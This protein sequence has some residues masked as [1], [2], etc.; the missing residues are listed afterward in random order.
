MATPSSPTRVTEIFTFVTEGGVAIEDEFIP[1]DTDDENVDWAEYWDG[2]NDSDDPDSDYGIDWDVS[3]QE[4]LVDDLDYALG[5]QG[6][7][8]WCE[9]KYAN[10]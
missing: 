2:Y 7:A 8:E 5:V 9:A 3:L 1:P 4:S 10:E 6:Y